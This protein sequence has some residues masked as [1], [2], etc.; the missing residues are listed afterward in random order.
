MDS[1]VVAHA[2]SNRFC[3]GSGSSA[4]YCTAQHRPMAAKIYELVKSQTFKFIEAWGKICKSTQHDNLHFQNLS[5][6]IK[7]E[8]PYHLRPIT[9][10]TF[11]SNISLSILTGATENSREEMLLATLSQC[12]TPRRA[13]P[14]V[15]VLCVVAVMDRLL[16]HCKQLLYR[17]NWKQRGRR[18]T[19]ANSRWKQKHREKKA[20]RLT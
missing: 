14:P 6:S 20:W 19:S 4:P 10:C 15:A 18:G 12:A 9:C 5:V 8:L 7:C 16:Q 1:T 2:D 11:S 17:G 13:L 3:V